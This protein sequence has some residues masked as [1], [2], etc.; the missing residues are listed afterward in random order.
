MFSSEAHISAVL[1]YSFGK[2]LSNCSIIAN[3]QSKGVVVK[4]TTQG[5][6][7]FFLDYA[8]FALETDIDNDS[9][10]PIIEYTITA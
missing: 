7:V 10:E 8:I 1:D 5:Y 3:Q 4:P 2:Y 6:N 9:V